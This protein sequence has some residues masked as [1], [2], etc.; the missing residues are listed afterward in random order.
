MLKT[1]SLADSVKLNE[2]FTISFLLH[3]CL[4]RLVFKG[5]MILPEDHNNPVYILKEM[6]RRLRA[7]GY[8]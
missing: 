7:V 1:I 3:G 4:L 5:S 2:Y 6:V 8:T